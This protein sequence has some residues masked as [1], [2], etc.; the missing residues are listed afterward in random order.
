MP[1][2]DDQDIQIET[3]LVRAL[4]IRDYIEN[5][6][7]TLG[8]HPECELKLTWHRNSAYHKAEF[9]KDI[10]AIANSAISEDKDK[11]IV[12]GV[13]QE[14]K[15]I[16]G[17]SHSDFDDAAIRQFLENY[18]D[19]IPD[20]EVLC[21]QASTGKDFVV[22]RFPHQIKK[23]FIAKSQI[24]DDKK[25]YL[26]EGEIWLKP[27]SAETGSS[28]KRRIK[29]RTEIIGLIDIEPY[30]KQAIS[31]RLE[32]VIPTIRLEERT[33]L[34]GQG[35]N[36]I[37]ALASSDE[38]FQSHIEQLFLNPSWNHVG[39]INVLVEKLRE[40]TVEVW[41]VE[42]DEGGYTSRLSPQDI[43]QI[44]ETEFLPAIRR[45]VLLGQLLIKFSAP[46]ECFAKIA[47]ILLQIFNVSNKLAKAI[48][49]VSRHAETSSLNEHNSFSVPALESLIATY[50]LA[51]YE[52]NRRNKN[53]YSRHLL[54]KIVGY[55]KAQEGISSKDFFMFWPITT[56]WGYPNRRRDLLVTERYSNAD[57]IGKLAGGEKCI[58]ESS[59]QI[60]CLIDWHSFL[61]FQEQGEPETIRFYQEFYS[62][63]STS[64]RPHFIKEPYEQIVPLID[65]LWEAIHTDGQNDFWLFDS[66][67]SKVFGGIDLARRKCL[68]ARFLLSLEAIQEEY[69]SQ[70]RRGPYWMP[71]RSDI[72]QFV[73][74][75]RKTITR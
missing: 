71:W 50:F 19:P 67:L 39:V 68:F 47:D 14:T 35:I 8:E 40:K 20:F 21:L 27:G 2:P 49:G 23:P 55:V 12:I 52:L 70:Q 1:T 24:K 48:V 51:G 46:Q 54:T 33:R 75:V 32:K 53:L 43:Q 31:E 63:I 62:G 25:V 10:Q 57:N 38:E 69:Q 45:L 58:K 42:P 16:E 41:D 13:N 9:V 28:G 6:I 36:S 29:S 73:E 74:E 59:L 56:G 26:E 11:Y 18:L 15:I 7:A 4:R 34:Q 3:T 72:A 61:S 17:C 5:M 64:F 44:K 60:E 30:V 65:K 37:S 22:L 66:R